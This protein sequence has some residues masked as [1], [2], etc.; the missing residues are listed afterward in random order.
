MRSLFALLACALAGCA[1]SNIEPSH[2][3]KE[4]RQAGV[5][6]GSITYQGSY[7]AYVLHAVEKTT[8]KTYRIQHGSSQTLN[9]VLAFKGEDPH[10]GLGRK[11]SPFAVE[12]PAGNYT[13]NAWQVSVGPANIFSTGPLGVEFTVAPGQAIYLGNYHFR[14]TS[15]VARLPT[16]AA[17][18][19]MNRSENDLPA[20]RSS[21]PALANV[22]LTQTI[23]AG[24]KLENLGGSSSSS[25]TMPVFV[26][27][28]R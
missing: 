27:V 13:L 5:A 19:L 24:A 20:I 22:E 8:G 4:A 7:G 6:T 3:L 9:P 16:G 18:T 2:N 11:G 1:V 21:F 25:I 10:P 28:A 23:V 14:E 15:R 12:L 17:V 26:P